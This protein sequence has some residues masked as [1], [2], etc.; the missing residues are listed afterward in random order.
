MS[1]CVIQKHTCTI[2]HINNQV[3]WNHTYGYSCTGGNFTNSRQTQEYLS[4]PVKEILLFPEERQMEGKLLNSA[5][6]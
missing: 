5:A 2:M 4:D 6:L 1:K 3:E